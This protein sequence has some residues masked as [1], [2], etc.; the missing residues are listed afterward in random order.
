M[1]C[2]RAGKDSYLDYIG[3][4]ILAMFRTIPHGVLVFF[5]SYTHLQLTIQ[6]WKATGLWK[7]LEAVKQL[8][9]EV[10]PLSAACCRVGGTEKTRQ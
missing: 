10:V 8:F 2:V 6:R 4:C 7:S 5:A 1:L 3:S 9:Q